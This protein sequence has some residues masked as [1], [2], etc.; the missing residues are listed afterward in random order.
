M[1]Q[2]Y[3]QNSLARLTTRL[4]WPPGPVDPGEGHDLDNS[5][6]NILT[7]YTALYVHTGHLCA[8]MKVFTTYR[9]RVMP[10]RIGH[11]WTQNEDIL[12]TLR[13]IVAAADPG[14]DV[15][16]SYRKF[17]I[18]NPTYKSCVAQRSV[19]ILKHFSFETP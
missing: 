4:V 15:F 2:D 14:V 19:N 8:N 5:N 13:S 1:K 6:A 11:R 9:P 10:T 17:A 12:L 18:F 16:S 3:N 7:I